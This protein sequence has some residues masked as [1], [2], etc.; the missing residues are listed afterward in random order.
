MDFP[1]AVERRV[2]VTYRTAPAVRPH[3]DAKGL[4]PEVAGRVAWRS[5]GYLLWTGTPWAGNIGK[6]T[7]RIHYSDGLPKPLVR[8]LRPPWHHWRAAPPPSPWTYDE[9]TRTD[10]AVFEDFEPKYGFDVEFGY[11]AVTVA[12]EIDLLVAALRGGADFGSGH[13]GLQR[14]A[15]MIEGAKEGMAE[16]DRTEKLMYVYGRYAESLDR[17]VAVLESRA[18]QVL[19]PLMSYGPAEGLYSA[20]GFAVRALKALVAH[21]DKAGRKGEALAE[22]GRLDRLLSAAAGYWQARAEVNDKAAAEKN[23]KGDARAAENARR[24]AAESREKLQAVQA[25]QTAL[26]AY[27]KGNGKPLAAG[28]K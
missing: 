8:S 13:Y 15:L 2:E 4:T 16:A 6:A 1:R 26:A 18:R 21:H 22:A 5:N 9:K 28:A 17:E 24:C 14:L 27:L 7:V 20:D 3:D 12:G 11:K 19:G 23:A 10:T 25:E